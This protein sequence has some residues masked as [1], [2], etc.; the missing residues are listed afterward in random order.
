[1]K[2]ECRLYFKERGYDDIQ[3]PNDPVIN[4]FNADFTESLVRESIQNSLDAAAEP[5]NPDMPVKVKFGFG[6]IKKDELSC[7]F[8]LKEHAEACLDKWKTKPRTQEIYEP[9]IKLLDHDEIS[10]IEVTDW[11]TTGMSNLPDKNGDKVFEIFTQST[12]VDVKSGANSAGSF[13]FGKAAFFL[14][15]PIR[16]ILV[17]SKTAL[18]E[19]NFAGRTKFCDH[20]LNG[21]EYGPK[22]YISPNPDFIPASDDQIPGQFEIDHVGTRITIVGQYTNTWT[23]T[24]MVNNLTKSV[25]VNF[26]LAIHEKKLCVE[27]GNDIAINS[28]NLGYYMESFF[29]TLQDKSRTYSPRPYYEAYVHGKEQDQFHKYYC[30]NI[31]PLGDVELYL[32]LPEDAKKDGLSRYRMQMMLIDHFEP[33]ASIGY[34]ALILCKDPKGNEYLSSIENARHNSWSTDG[35]TGDDFTKASEVLRALDDY[36]NRKVELSLD[37]QREKVSIITG[38]ESLI[39]SSGNDVDNPFNNDNN[40]FIS[41][42]DVDD[43]KKEKSNNPKDKGM[44]GESL[45]GL[46]TEE[47]KKLIEQGKKKKK[48]VPPPPPPPPPPILYPERGKREEKGIE[49]GNRDKFLLFHPTRW[50]APG[51]YINGIGH[52]YLKIHSN[53]EMKKVMIDVEVL[54]DSPKAPPVKIKEVIGAKAIISKSSS[55]NDRTASGT[56]LLI[57][58]LPVGVTI[59]EIVFEDNECHS[60]ILK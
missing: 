15:S 54:S 46:L 57:E 60:I 23:Q 38:I 7:L 12:G 3:G 27:I 36:V 47:D 28:G 26:W 22:G 50:N 19:T 56:K 13:G 51:K 35:K 20:F 58:E 55:I 18:G 34:Y 43:E 4:T 10:T 1:M 31:P 14:M 33:R 41:K 49:E 30:E 11:N 52:Q 16:T 59:F 48:I 21:K 6:V 53:K 37:V 5:N 42:Q 25:L 8:E 29:P 9:M 44:L 45:E 32:Y 39:T 17:S 40:A 2:R 24:D